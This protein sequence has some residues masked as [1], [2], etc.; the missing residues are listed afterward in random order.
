[1]EKIKGKMYNVRKWNVG[2]SQYENISHGLGKE[3]A[4]ELWMH[5]ALFQRKKKQWGKATVLKQ[6][7]KQKNTTHCDLIQNP[8]VDE[9]VP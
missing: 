1:M 7:N 8:P 4:K 6:T 2:F 3:V 5:A 9:I